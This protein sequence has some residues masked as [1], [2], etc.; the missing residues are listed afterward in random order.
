MFDR[1][2]EREN[3]PKILFQ[4]H[5]HAQAAA[6]PENDNKDVEAQNQANN[7]AL[8]LSRP[9]V[10]AI[11]YHGDQIVLDGDNHP[12]KRY[13]EIPA[14]CSS[15]IEG[16][17]MVAI[18]RSN[19]NI[20]TQ[21]I[22]ARMPH[23]RTFTAD[24]EGDKKQWSLQA[25]TM[26][27][28]RFLM[29]SASLSWDKRGGSDKFAEYLESILPEDC[30]EQNST[31]TFH[32][33]DEVEI[34][35]MKAKNLGNFG[36]RTKKKD[37][38]EEPVKGEKSEETCADKDKTHA[39]ERGKND[40]NGKRKHLAMLDEDFDED[41]DE[42]SLGEPN[43]KKQKLLP[44]PIRPSR[45]RVGKAK[46]PRKQQNIIQERQDGAGYFH[47]ENAH[48][49]APNV[50]AYDPHDGTYMPYILPPPMNPFSH[51]DEQDFQAPH[52]PDEI[53]DIQ[54]PYQDFN[55]PIAS[56]Q[57]VLEQEQ[58]LDLGDDAA[59]IHNPQEPHPNNLDPALFA[60]RFGAPGNDLELDLHQFLNEEFLNDFGGEA[61]A[62]S[63]DYTAII[64][65][66]LGL[67][68]D[69]EG[70]WPETDPS[71]PIESNVGPQT[72][73]V[74]NC[75]GGSDT[76]LGVSVGDDGSQT[77]LDLPTSTNDDGNNFTLDFPPDNE[78]E[79]ALGLAFTAEEFDEIVREIFRN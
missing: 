18:R 4:L 34:Q 55:N 10:A 12:V 28:T 14:T 36:Y 73:A 25:H 53:P 31:E 62:A 56:A 7:D 65:A 32:D 69:T 17:L 41:F 58:L 21:D 24:G 66:A 11:W 57:Q 78:A 47:E 44:R 8:D 2:G 52:I 1:G 35:Q 16:W 67:N 76:T 38:Q 45:S 60:T 51:A 37:N 70:T 39:L 48:T 63:N 75:L 3:R 72:P 79:A 50:D 40:G 49:T 42:A 64:D 13:K 22:R 68:P 15:E 26:R 77:P 54:S 5:K 43:P 27:Q 71:H 61:S 19:P 29:R 46:G 74:Q 33:L 9:R 30:I 23:F 20:A 6:K 59:F